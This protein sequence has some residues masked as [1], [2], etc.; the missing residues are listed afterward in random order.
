M[1]RHLFHLNEKMYIRIIVHQSYCDFVV[2][3]T[4]CFYLRHSLS[5][6]INELSIEA[7]RQPIYV[8]AEKKSV[9]K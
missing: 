8:I 1:F 6:L 5:N 3:S 9:K 2:S 4:I 7:I